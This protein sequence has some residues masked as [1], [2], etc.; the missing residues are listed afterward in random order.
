MSIANRPKYEY[1]P[2]DVLTYI[3]NVV[4]LIS[5]VASAEV[6]L[7]QEEVSGDVDILLESIEKIRATIRHEV[8]KFGVSGSTYS[9][10]IPTRY[11]FKD[12]PTADLD[13]TTHRA[14][15][16]VDVHPSGRIDVPIPADQEPWWWR[17]EE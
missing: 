11:H 2:E 1:Q 16:V 15:T 8:D 13:G 3:G 6:Y 4:E 14:S 5:A 17:K 12:E 10:G 9:N 7:S